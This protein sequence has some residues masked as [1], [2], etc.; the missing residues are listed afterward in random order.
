MTHSYKAIFTFLFLALCGKAH[1]QEAVP[2]SLDECYTYAHDHA[3]TLK[4]TRLNIDLQKSTNDQIQ[5]SVLPHINGSGEFDYYIQP[6]QSFLPGQFFNMPEGTFVP[7]TFTPTYNTTATISGTQPLFDGTLLIALK[8]RK[9]VLDLV[10]E[11][12]KLTEENLRYGIQRAY[13]NIVVAQNQLR[14]FAASLANAR[15]VAHDFDVLHTTGFGEQIDVDRSSVT[16]NNLQND[17]INIANLISVSQQLLKYEIG[18]DIKQP[19]VLTDTSLDQQVALAA[20]S[21][22][23]NLEYESITAYR[24][25]NM[26]LVLNQY[27]LKRYQVAAYPTLSGFGRIGANYASNTFNEVTKYRNYL[28]NSVIG[29]TL[30]V[31]IFNGFLRRSQ[32]TSAKIQIE[33]TKNNI[34]LLQRTIDFQSAQSRTNLH[35]A[36]LSL[37][38]Q[39][40]NIALASS[41][42]DLATK[43][44]KAGV[45][46]N[47]EVTTAQNELLQ[48]QNNYFTALQNVIN[49][50]S[51]LQLALGDFKIQ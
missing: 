8:A 27:D 35:N 17:S 20:R 3:D 11:S 32:V 30:N 2:L 10:R 18:M 46:S 50:Q 25:L 44:Y 51:D 49:A 6:I 38:S 41:V 22:D 4:N 21:V 40:R 37:Q 33:K 28:N 39:K 1:A 36:L 29:V 15:D 42:V 23:E 47:L 9:A 48:T 45:G 16:V 14:I 31:P 13:Y 5:A 26:T 19:I 24:L 12:A 43:K 7:V 34:H